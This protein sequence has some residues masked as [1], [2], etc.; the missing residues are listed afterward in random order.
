[1]LPSIDSEGSIARTKKPQAKVDFAKT[2][3]RWGWFNAGRRMSEDKYQFLVLSQCA[4][5]ILYKSTGSASL[6]V[7][8]EIVPGS[9]N[10]L[11]KTRYSFSKTVEFAA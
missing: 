6:V 2:M 3:L 10:H 11:S 8:H 7:L 5:L 4:H 9:E 1:V